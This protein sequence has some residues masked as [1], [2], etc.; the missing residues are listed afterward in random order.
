MRGS[1]F[2]IWKDH[3]RGLR[4][5]TEIKCYSDRKRPIFGYSVSVY[6]H[7]SEYMKCFSRFQL[8]ANYISQVLF[9]S[10]QP[11]RN[12]NLL[13]IELDVFSLITECRIRKHWNLLLTIVERSRLFVGFNL[14]YHLTLRALICINCMVRKILEFPNLDW[15]K[16]SN[17]LVF[18]LFTLCGTYTKTIIHPRVRVSERY[19]PLFTTP[20]LRWMIVNY[21]NNFFF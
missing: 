20:S 18:Y 7:K 19:P 4:S 12:E 16:L 10:E 6:A 17:F 14:T 11:G 13:R 9:T 21:L 15:R 3:N 1:T 2:N 5:C 8:G